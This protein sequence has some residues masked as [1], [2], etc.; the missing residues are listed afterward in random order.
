MQ[1]AFHVAYIDVTRPNGT[2]SYKSD[3]IADRTVRQM[4]DYANDF[5]NYYDFV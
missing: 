2:N 5:F 1:V 4:I 3:I